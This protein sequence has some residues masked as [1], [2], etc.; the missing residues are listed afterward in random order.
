MGRKKSNMLGVF[1][2]LTREQMQQLDII[3]AHRHTNRAQLIR[4]A[5]ARFLETILGGSGQD[6]KDHVS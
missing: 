3:C 2:R 6:R 1:T 5:V 4:E